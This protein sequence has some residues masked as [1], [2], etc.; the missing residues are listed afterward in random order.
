MDNP[1]S[2]PTHFLSKDQNEG[3]SRNSLVWILLHC[4]VPQVSLKNFLILRPRLPWRTSGQFQARLPNPNPGFVDASN[5][6]IGCGT[7]PLRF[8]SHLSNC[9]DDNTIM[10]MVNILIIWVFKPSGWCFQSFPCSPWSPHSSCSP[11]R[12]GRI[13]QF[14]EPALKRWVHLLLKTPQILTIKRKIF[15]ILGIFLM[16][17]FAAGQK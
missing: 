3:Q 17:G 4:D 16:S 2:L 5:T 7:L 13:P 9:Q 11:F 15:A 6:R 14:V 12:N 10:I 8:L 1:F